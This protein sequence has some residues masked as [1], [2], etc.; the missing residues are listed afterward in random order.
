M[1]AST[2]ANGQTKPPVEV[3]DPEI[4]IPAGFGPGISGKVLFYL[5]LAFS[6]FQLFTACYAILPAIV[7]RAM[8]VGF[9]MLI[10][11]ALLANHKA[12][13]PFTWALGWLAGIAGFSVGVYHW[14]FYNDLIFRTGDLNTTDLVVGVVTLGVLYYMAWR[15]LGPALPILEGIFLTYCFFGNY[16]PPPLNHRGYDFSQIIEH[17][18]FGTEGTYG[19]PTGVSATYIFL[20]ILFGTFLEKAGMI[21]LFNDIAIAAVGRM[22]GGPAKVAVVSSGLMGM[23]SGSGVA[24]VVAVGQFTIP[25]MKRFGYRPAFAGGVEATSSMGAQIMPPVMGAVAF[26][27]AETLNVPYTDIVQAAIVPALL[28]YFSAFWAVHLEAGKYGLLGFSGEQIPNVWQ[29]LKRQWFLLLPLITLCALLFAGFTPLYAGAAGLALTMLLILGASAA[30]QLPHIVMKIIFWAVLGFGTGIIYDTGLTFAGMRFKG[31]DIIIGVVA[32]LVLVNLLSRGGRKTLILCR[33]SLAEGARQ[34]LPVGIACA[35]VGAV[36]GTMT[37]TGLGTTFGSWVIEIGKDS[38]LAA[39]VLTMIASLI[40]GMGVPTI[41]NYII[42]STIAAPVLFKLGVP[43]IISHMFCFYFGIMAD[44][45]PPVALAAFA[46]SSIARES[47]DKIGWEAM[48]IAVPGFVV[49]FM[50]VY[51]HTLMLQGA[52]NAPSFAAFAAETGYVIGKAMFAVMLWGTASIGFFMKRYVVWERIA[53][54]LAACLLAVA[55]PWTDTAGFILG[56]AVLAQHWY[57]T[58]QT[59]SAAATGQA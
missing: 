44:L 56:A 11:A 21:Q 18:A 50:A 53:A 58:R 26:I 42:T 43:L 55:I 7:V 1:S 39:L 14:V 22:R 46:A 29:T 57:R 23:I 49:P 12:K 33:D 20:F 35:S 16:L 54:A 52:E 31:I 32:L 30:L 41:P 8:H 28:Y 3:V 13:T 25:L 2:A 4:G 59:Q 37:L 9:L 10:G 6:F 51:D 17:M 40:L 15:V 34:A 24:N 38:L 48:R 47:A 36:I 5:A 45:T 27:M 19:T